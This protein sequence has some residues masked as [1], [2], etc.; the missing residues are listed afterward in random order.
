MCGV[1]G[2]ARRGVPPSAVLP[3]GAALRAAAAP[4]RAAGALR[5]LRRR[6]AGAAPSSHGLLVPCARSVAGRPAAPSPP[7]PR[8]TCPPAPGSP[9]ATQIAQQPHRAATRHFFSPPET[10][11]ARGSCFYLP[12]GARHSPRPICRAHRCALR[13]GAGTDSFFPRYSRDEC[14]D[15]PS[16]PCKGGQPLVPGP[17]PCVLS[18]TQTHSTPESWNP[19]MCGICKG[20]V[21]IYKGRVFTTFLVPG[22]FLDTFVTN[23]ENLNRTDRK[24]LNRT[25]RSNR[26]MSPNRPLYL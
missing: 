13:I 19:K 12:S 3:G 5:P 23:F 2:A 10:R 4:L 16:R 21:C 7:Q 6:A 20:R 9:V 18:F 17:N 22:N 25:D 8:P 11:T 1:R 24:N 14:R 15:F 26:S